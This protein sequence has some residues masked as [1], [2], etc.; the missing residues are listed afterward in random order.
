MKF[1]FHFYCDAG[2]YN[3]FKPEKTKSCSHSLAL[4][5]IEAEKIQLPSSDT[6]PGGTFKVKGIKEIN[7]T[8]NVIIFNIEKV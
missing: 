7:F 2:P 8:H 1:D 3:I 5:L 6:S 4:T